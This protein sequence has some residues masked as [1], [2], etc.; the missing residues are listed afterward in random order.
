MYHSTPKKGPL[1][2]FSKI[3]DKGHFGQPKV[4]FGDSGINEPVID[5][6]GIYGMTQHAMGIQIENENEGIE[7]SKALISI[8]MKVLIDSCLFSSYAIDWNIFKDM[9]KDLWKEFM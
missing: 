5:I 8:K 2:K 9:K 7:L 3:N 1:Y 6:N 4:I